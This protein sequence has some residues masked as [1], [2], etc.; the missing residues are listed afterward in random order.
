MGIF[1]LRKP[2]PDISEETNRFGGYKLYAPNGQEI[3]VGDDICAG[4]ILVFEFIYKRISAQ[5][6]DRSCVQRHLYMVAFSVIVDCANIPAA[7]MEVYFQCVQII[8]AGI[9]LQ[10]LLYH[11][12]NQ[13]ADLRLLAGEARSRRSASWL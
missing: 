8:T 4:S 1:T 6:P 3:A 5:F 12:D 7:V 9:A 2:T 11:I 13:L 10:I